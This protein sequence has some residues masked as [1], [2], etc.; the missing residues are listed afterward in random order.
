MPGRRGWKWDLAGGD[1]ELWSN[2]TKIADISTTAITFVDGINIAV[3][4]TTGTKIGT[5]TTQKLGFYSA[6]PVARQ[7]HVADAPAG[8][9]GAAAGGWDTAA[10]RDAAIASINAVLS[11]LETLGFFATS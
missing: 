9:T 10:N 3:N 2:G 7:T 5:A 11:R 1:L 6:T 4:T 8:G